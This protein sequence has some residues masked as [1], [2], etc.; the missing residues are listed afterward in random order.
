MKVRVPQYLH[1]PPQ[2]LWFDAQ[3]IL[4][5]MAAYL[6]S[7]SFKGYSWVVLIGIAWFFIRFKR[8][9]PRG[10]I[11]HLFYRTGLFQL[12]GYPLPTAR[13]FYE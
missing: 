2:I 11:L 7:V 4:V 12:K 13:K 1:L 5:L 9:K 6:G 8:Q 10:Y 3:E